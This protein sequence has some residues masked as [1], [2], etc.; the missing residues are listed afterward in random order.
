[1]IFKAAN[2]Q[3][4]KPIKAAVHLMLRCSNIVFPPKA[5]VLYCTVQDIIHYTL[6]MFFGCLPGGTLQ[7]SISCQNGFQVEPVLFLFFLE[8]NTR[9]YPTN[10]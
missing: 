9:Y 2:K 10:P 1:M 7:Q 6:K 3:R 8:E 5:S 4:K